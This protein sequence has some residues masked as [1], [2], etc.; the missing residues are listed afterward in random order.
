MVPAEVG[1]EER[2]AEARGVVQ[3]LTDGRGRGRR[4]QDRGVA[5]ETIED[6]QVGGRRNDRGDRVVEVELP[7]LGELQDAGGDHRLRHR[8]DPEE[9][10]GRYRITAGGTGVPKPDS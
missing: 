4:P 5:V 10:I 7:T 6:L 1:V 2:I 8:G 3:E 9:L